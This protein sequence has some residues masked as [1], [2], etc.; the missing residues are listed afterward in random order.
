M[1]G[2]L[3]IVETLVAAGA[4]VDVKNENGMK[5]ADSVGRWRYDMSEDAKEEIQKV[6][7]S[8]GENFNLFPIVPPRWMGPFFSRAY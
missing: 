6:L 4:D 1:N 5:A 3:K 8:Q 2:L 7:M